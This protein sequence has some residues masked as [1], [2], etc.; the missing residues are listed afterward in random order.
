MDCYCIRNRKISKR[1]EIV[2]KH[3]EDITQYWKKIDK[4]TSK[5]QSKEG[6]S[7]KIECSY[8]M[9]GFIG[10]K[11][12]YKQAIYKE[13]PH[14]FCSEE[15]WIYWAKQPRILSKH[16]FCSPILSSSLTPTSPEYMKYFDSNNNDININKI[17]S[18]S[19]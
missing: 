5:E 11:P 10:E 6:K 7:K 19:I 17:P 4:I 16:N 15:C 2:K 9:C 18:L 12:L 13:I 1:N 3:K 14:Y 8:L